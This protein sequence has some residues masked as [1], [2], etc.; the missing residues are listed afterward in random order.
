MKFKGARAR[1]F[2][3]QKKIFCSYFGIFW[4]S[5]GCKKIGPKIGLSLNWSSHP[6]GISTFNG[7]KKGL[8]VICHRSKEKAKSC[9]KI[10]F[11]NAIDH[12]CNRRTFYVKLHV[13]NVSSEQ[14][15]KQTNFTNKSRYL[16]T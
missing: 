8:A 5:G 9:S 10:Y 15:N 4:V 3:E 16:A 2:I 1:N 6:S 11:L 12:Q 7:L 13:S 14:T